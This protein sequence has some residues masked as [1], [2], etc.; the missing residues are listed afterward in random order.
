MYEASG[1]GI[2]RQGDALLMKAAGGAGAVG[3][4]LH[5]AVPIAMIGF[6]LLLGGAM[7]W[8]ALQAFTPAPAFLPVLTGLFTL[9][10]GLVLAL[11]SLSL[12]GAGLTHLF[13]PTRR[14]RL[15]SRLQWTATVFLTLLGAL[16]YLEM[17]LRLFEGFGRSVALA[18]TVLFAVLA[19][20]S[21][22]FAVWSH[23]WGSRE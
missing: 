19:L 2:Q 4:W 10:F 22:S 13:P 18:K 7:G 9:A 11:A 6:D 20:V 5:A 8:F 3:Q 21:L 12:V 14:V 1:R 16:S 15:S 17:Y 23:F